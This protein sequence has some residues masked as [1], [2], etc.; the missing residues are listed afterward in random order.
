MS[1][2]HN[3]TGHDTISQIVPSLEKS[4]PKIDS[5]DPKLL[6]T[7][8]SRYASIVGESKNVK[9]LL[10]CLISKD[11]PK[12]YRTS[13]II[14]NQSSTG[15]SYLLNKVLEPF[16]DDK[17]TVLDFT[18]MTEAY[19]KRSLH[20]VNNK[21]I[22]IEQLENRNENGQISIHRLKHLLSEG[23]LC[24]GQ[25]DSDET[26]KNK[27]AKVFEVVGIPVI[28]TTA[29]EFGIDSETQNRFFMMQL[30]ES[31]E[32]TGRI[33]DHT[34]TDYNKIDG[35]DHRDTELSKFYENLG[36]MGRR[37]RGFMIPF[38]DK[39]KPLLPK[40]LPMR[41]DLDKILNLTCQHAF[42]HAK[43]RDY[44][45]TAKDLLIPLEGDKNEKQDI[46]EKA[47]FYYF[48][49]KPE[50]FQA[51]YEMAGDTISQTINKSSHRLMAMNATLRKLYNVQKIDEQAGIT[52]KQL[53]KPTDLTENRVREYV[54]ELVNRGF[55][56]RDDSDKE[57]KYIPTDKRFSELS[58]ANIEF[59]DTE[60]KDWVAQT[61]EDAGDT[62]SFVSQ[63]DGKGGQNEL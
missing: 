25:Y 54:N 18:D 61:L 4:T 23:R 20:N 28:V 13:V 5:K 43:N 24:F 17:N 27:K 6:D 35:D 3:K 30:D 34:L 52:V 55:A 16:K 62:F 7:I 8:A 21:I 36:K 14:S 33:I 57:Y 60:Y 59:S 9:T 39:I 58:A 40:E 49:C 38:T 19:I 50:D 37:T 15:K 44:F 10:C 2:S 51:A 47:E 31:E 63:C 42:I 56:T 48:I 12:K 1:P 41:R 45:V 11:L 26:D 46:T 22:K 29:T 53:T 32:Q